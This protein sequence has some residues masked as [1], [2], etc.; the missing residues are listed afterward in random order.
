MIFPSISDLRA[1]GEGYVGM[2]EHLTVLS[3]AQN[4]VTQSRVGRDFSLFVARLMYPIRELDEIAYLY[5]FY[6]KCRGRFRAFTFTDYNGWDAETKPLLPVP[7]LVEKGDG[8]STLFD[9]PVRFSSGLVLQIDSGDPMEIGSGWGA[10]SGSGRDGRD[11]ATFDTPPGDGS[12][13]KVVGGRG[14]QC[15]DAAFTQDLLSIDHFAN[16]L[17]SVRGVEIKERRGGCHVVLNP[18]SGSFPD[19]TLLMDYTD[20]TIIASHGLFPFTFSI[21]SGSPPT[22]MTLETTPP[23]TAQVTGTP[24]ATGSFEFILRAMDARGCY[25]DNEYLIAIGCST[26]TVSPTSLAAASVDASYSDTVSASGGVAPYTFAVTTGTLPSGLSLDPDTGIISGTPTGAGSHTFTITA[27]DANGCTG[28]REYVLAPDCPAITITGSTVAATLGTAYSRTFG[29]TGGASPYT[30]STSGSVPPGL[31]IDSSS[32]VLSGTPTTSGTYTFNVIVS[33]DNGCPGEK[34]FEIVASCPGITV[35]PS[36]ISGVTVGAALATTTITASGGTASYTFAVTSGTLPTGTSLSSGGSLSGSTTASG[37]FSFTITATDAYGCTGSRAYNVT[38]CPTI[39]L[40]MKKNSDG[41]TQNSPY[42]FTNHSIDCL[43]ALHH[44][45]ATGGIAPYT[46]SKT[47]TMP[48][49]WTLNS[50]GTITGNF[51]DNSE[52]RTLTFTATDANG[53][54]GSLSFQFIL[55][56]TL[57]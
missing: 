32:G 56:T 42:S 53:C 6:R 27:T 10:T 44:L 33:D 15:V 30:F 45:L 5:D 19:G 1:P 39:T 55:D 11:T 38:I 4:S 47:G 23:N 48:T 57:I 52:T 40:L 14:L 34:E 29:A 37:V 43:A 18:G 36:S 13:I 21:L 2:R 20:A 9:L 25:L 3:Y 26:I 41:S 24:T 50:D 31:S 28:H 8:V 46:Y 7:L 17:V 22:G 35:S 12:I 51:C 49:G 16:E 54:T